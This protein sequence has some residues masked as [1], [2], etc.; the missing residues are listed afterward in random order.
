MIRVGESINK[1]VHMELFM[2]L[3]L[4]AMESRPLKEFLE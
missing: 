2:E 4:Q 3:T 1:S